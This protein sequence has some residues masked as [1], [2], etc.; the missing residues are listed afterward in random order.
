MAKLSKICNCIASKNLD[1]GDKVTIYDQFLGNTLKNDT[2]CKIVGRYAGLFGDYCFDVKR[3][4]EERG[5]IG[6]GGYLAN[7]L[8]KVDTLK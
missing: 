4:D 2:L 8:K 3:F 6:C 7:N 1:I 5:W